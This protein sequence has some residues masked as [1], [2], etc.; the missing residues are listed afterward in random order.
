MA[1]DSA[2]IASQLA[3]F[4]VQPFETKYQNKI[5]TAQNQLSAYAKIKSSLES[6]DDKIYDLN[7]AGES[8]GKSSTSLSSDE[9]FDLT[10]SSGISNMNMDIFVEQLATSHQVVMDVSATTMDEDI[11]SGGTF[12]I[13]V[14]G[15]T[16]SLDLTQADIDGSGSVSMSEF[17]D[18][19]NANSEHV[20]VSVLR[21]NGE[22]KLMFTSLETG[23][24]NSFQI[25]ASSGSGLESQAAAANANPIKQGQDAIIWLGSEGSGTKLVNSS[26]QF[27]NVIEDITINLK[28]S[29]QSGDDSI[30]TVV[31]SDPDATLES[32]KE[33]VSLFNDSLSTVSKY[34]GTG[35]QDELRGVLSS[36]YSMR[37]L[38]TQFK[39]VLRSDFDGVR[40]FEIGIEFDRDGKLTIDEDKFEDNI[41]KVNLDK[42]FKAEG[43]VFER[44]TDTLDQY[45][46]FSTGIIQ[47]KRD[48]LN[49]NI[50]S[51]NDNLTKLDERYDRLYSQYLAQ[52]NVVNEMESKLNSLSSLFI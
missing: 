3:G 18:H 11:A 35:S 47:T 22:M 8:L 48:S 9:F 44:L 41:E 28:K 40:L 51:Y 52:F 27:E 24:D 17:V 10:A 25:S 36:D 26:N 42:L 31:A 19:F 13:T 14:N 23:A 21:T 34:T 7:K 49:S 43:G 12:D 1:I 15:E 45:T 5:T 29:Q 37:S 16:T 2:S 46:D 20:S 39:N 32:L 33:L 4:D 50:D 6:L 38:D 30:N